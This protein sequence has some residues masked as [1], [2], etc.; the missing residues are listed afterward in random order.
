[1]VFWDVQ[2]G[3]ATYLKTPNERHIVIDL[4]TGSYSDDKTEFS[5]LTHIKN[6]YKV[7]K[8]DYVIITHPHLDHID[9]VLNFD[10]LSPKVLNRPKTLSNEKIMSGA[11]DKDKPKFKKYC[12]INDRYNRDVTGSVYC[13][14]NPENWGGLKITT[15]R[16][17]ECDDDNPN[18]HSSVTI[19]EYANTKVVIPGDNESTSL[20]Y[21][22]EN[23]LFLKA[24]KDA[25]ILL[26]P[27]H[28]RESGYNSDFVKAVSPCI[29][30]VSDG[31]KVD[32][33]AND[34]YSAI[35]RGWTVYN[36]SGGSKKRKC[37]STNSD[38]AIRIEFGDNYL[39]VKH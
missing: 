28:G 12:E 33:S 17:D 10:S 13:P 16:N 2:H 31:K 5:P 29:T 30:I 34:R 26:A 15:F 4:G 14:N 32:T 38:G 1:M 19:F 18:N 39:H 7:E 23:G 8:L 37:L 9:D 6:N 3:H 24:I 20:E 11:S 35:S 36:S 27:H 21:L 25:D 22:M